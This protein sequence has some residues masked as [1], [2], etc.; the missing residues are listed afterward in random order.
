MGAEAPMSH[1]LIRR[2]VFGLPILLIAVGE[3]GCAA[4]RPLPLVRPAN[5]AAV[6]N[7]ADVQLQPGTQCLVGLTGGEK[8]RGTC[9]SN[10]RDRLEFRWWDE[11]RA[12]ERRSSIPHGDITL[13]ARVV[14]MSKG[15]R[16]W[17]GAGIG[18]LVSVPF[19]I[20]IVGDMVVPAAIVGA[21]IGRATGNSRAEVIFERPDSSPVP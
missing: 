6:T 10:S 5:S 7:L 18:A 2:V 13:V 17:L 20:S 21:L 3:S 19:G 4:A 14:K 15:T 11:T 16:G 8:L 1:L 9:E 12:A